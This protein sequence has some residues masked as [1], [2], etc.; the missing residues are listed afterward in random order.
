MRRTLRRRVDDLV[1]VPRAAASANSK[2]CF[3]GDLRGERISEDNSCAGVDVQREV[4][5]EAEGMVVCPHVQLLLARQVTGL[6]GLGKAAL[7]SPGAVGPRRCSNPERSRCTHSRVRSTDE[8]TGCG[9]GLPGRGTEHIA[10][11][12][13]AGIPRQRRAHGDEKP[14]AEGGNNVVLSPPDRACKRSAYCAIAR[15]RLGEASVRP[16]LWS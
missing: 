5:Y 1:D 14:R 13:P 16:A 7:P 6:Q 8:L 12:G 10:K 3:P 9:A 11:S 15:A 4:F 2:R